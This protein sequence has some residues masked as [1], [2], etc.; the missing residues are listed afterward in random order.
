MAP[1]KKNKFMNNNKNKT[2]IALLHK[3]VAR[4][5]MYRYQKFC[6][7]LIDA[8]ELDR[9]TDVTADNAMN[10]PVNWKTIH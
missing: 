6:S 10:I 5:E 3:E 4:L 9:C 2:S 8:A 1:H 7:I